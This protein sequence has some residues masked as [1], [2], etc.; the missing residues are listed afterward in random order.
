MKT[1]LLQKEKDAVLLLRL[2]SSQ[3]PLYVCYS[4]GKD[5]DVIRILAEISGCNYELH[6]NLTTVDAPETVYYVQKFVKPE[7]IHKPARSMW[8]LI[9]EKMFPPTR[10]ARYCCS[11]LKEGGGFGRKKVT[12]VRHAE[13]PN[14]RKNQDLFTIIGKSKTIQKKA[15]EAN[16]NFQLTVKGGGCA[17]SG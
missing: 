7:F 16:V 4:G 5:S 9:E 10:I 3:D 14:R 8:K 11:E 12:G 17:E 2:M 15:I 1:E 6:H 13:S